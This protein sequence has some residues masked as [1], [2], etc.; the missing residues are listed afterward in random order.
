VLSLIDL[1]SVHSS[2]N[3]RNLFVVVYIMLTAFFVYYGVVYRHLTEGKLIAMTSMLFLGGLLDV[4]QAATNPLEKMGMEVINTSSGYVF[5][6]LLPLL[7][8]RYRNQSFWVF[9]L[10]LGLTAITGK[11]GALVIFAVLAGYYVLNLRIIGHSIR[12]NYKSV[13]AASLAFVAFVYFMEVAYESLIFRFENIVHPERGT[14]G[15]GRDVIWSTLLSHW[16][17]GDVFNFF[18]GYGFFS[19]SSIEGHIAH[20]DF[21]EF[22]FDFGVFGLMLYIFVLFKYFKNIQNVKQ[23]DKYLYFLLMTC[24]LIIIG[25]GMF[26]GTIRTDNI[27]LSISMGYLLAV[28][29]LKRLL[30]AKQN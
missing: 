16:Y 24:L 18:F 14:I 29:T 22:L 4:Y 19:T 6:M 8:Y 25:R 13:I 27:Y 26:A 30:Y 12:F 5:A 11:R 9:V 23:Y 15:S 20:N 21:I 1:P 2:K 17:H 10:L 7:M 28:A 3:P